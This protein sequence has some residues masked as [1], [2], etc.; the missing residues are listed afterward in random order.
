MQLMLKSLP[1]TER[2]RTARIAEKPLLN[3]AVDMDAVNLISSKELVR[4]STHEI[5]SQTPPRIWLGLRILSLHPLRTHARAYGI[6]CY[7]LDL[8][9][10]CTHGTYY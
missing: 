4:C 5:P 6:V 10:M 7:N 8:V 9:Y 1:F 2:E 3:D